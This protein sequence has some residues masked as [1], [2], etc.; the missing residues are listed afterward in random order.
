MISPCQARDDDDKPRI[1][2]L[3]TLWIHAAINMHFGR[4]AD[5][6]E[7]HLT[8]YVCVSVSLFPIDPGRNSSGDRL[9]STVH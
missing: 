3:H 7:R 5:C 9:N 1:W 4:P 2:P 6:P 8:D